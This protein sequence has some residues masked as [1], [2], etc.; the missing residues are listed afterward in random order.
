MAREA[1]GELRRGAAVQARVVHAIMLRET[2][3]RFGAYRL[4]YLWAILDPI[5]IILTFF[6]LFSLAN[7]RAPDGMDIFSFMTTGLIPFRLF[8]S[9]AT[10][11]GEAI[12][13]NRAL[14]YYPRVLPIDLVIARWLYE[15][16][17]YS[18]VFV[19]LIGGHAAYRQELTI[20]S[21]LHVVA[22]LFLASLL[23]AAV[24]LVFCCG[25]VL[26]NTMD[27]ARGPLLRPLFWI[28]GVFYTAAMLPDHVRELALLNPI[29]H[30]VELVR[31]GM[32]HSYDARH[33]DASFLLQCIIAVAL[34]GLL[35]ERSVRPRIQLT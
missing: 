2:R 12:N 29:L 7:R 30:A 25:G 18:A 34:A 27:R 31:A 22:G 3:T 14:L 24:G 10:Q 16:I 17:T 8:S 11:V 4:G 33:A 35:L 26:S 13:G 20:D 28:S 1:F 23:G 9:A 32:F 15:L 21:P 5:L 6:G 19:I